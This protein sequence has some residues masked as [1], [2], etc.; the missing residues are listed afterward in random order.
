MPV[1]DDDLD[2]HVLGIDFDGDDGATRQFVQASRNAFDCRQK[3]HS[4]N[5]PAC[6]LTVT[7]ACLGACKIVH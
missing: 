1:S 6:E 7:Q 4:M 3:V 5:D 2:G